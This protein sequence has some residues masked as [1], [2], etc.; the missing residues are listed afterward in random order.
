MISKGIILAGGVGSRV[1]PSTKAISKQLIPLADKPIIFY[2]LSILMLLNIR[3]ILI[4]VKK[5][6]Y[7]SFK[8]LLG[9]G[10]NY[11]ISIKFAIQRNPEVCQMLL[12][13]EKIYKKQ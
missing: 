9:N 6:D 8:R 13:L 1:G 11:G 3:N 5:D 2:S 4:I 10:K 12:L 7:S